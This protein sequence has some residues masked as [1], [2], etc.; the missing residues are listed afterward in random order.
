V[1]AVPP[2]VSVTVA[3]HAEATPTRTGVS[4]PTLVEV[5]RTVPV[6]CVDP[7]LEACRWSPP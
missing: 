2:S 5:C 6:I 1:I 7:V 4:H 3:V